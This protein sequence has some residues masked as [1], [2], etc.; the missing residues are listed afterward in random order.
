MS[1]TPD[2]KGNRIGAQTAAY[3]RSTHPINWAESHLGSALPVAGMLAGGGM[4]AA[5][6]PET[7]GAS[8]SGLGASAGTGGAA[9]L[10]GKQAIGKSLGVSDMDTD[11]IKQEGVNDAVMEMAGRGVGQLPLPNAVGGSVEG[12]LGK[13]GDMARTTVTKPLSYLAGLVTGVPRQA[14]EQ[15][16]NDP[17]GVAMANS[18]KTAKV[19]SGELSARNQ[20]LGRIVGQ[21]RE[22]ALKAR[23]DLSFD[24][25]GT[26]NEIGAN[27]DEGVRLGHITPEEGDKL[28]AI[29]DQYLTTPHTK[30]GIPAPATVRAPWQR[31]EL[32]PET[33][34]YRGKHPENGKGDWTLDP[35]E[36]RAH[37]GPEGVVQ[38]SVLGNLG[39]EGDLIGGYAG[40]VQPEGNQLVPGVMKNV[41]RGEAIPASQI[42][43]TREVPNPKKWTVPPKQTQLPAASMDQLVQGVGALSPGS[44]GPSQTAMSKMANDV[45]PQGSDKYMAQLAQMRGALKAVDDE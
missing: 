27:V 38:P 7:L 24:S 3:L 17:L 8:L 26:L 11:A 28:K 30:P 19:A 36:A 35:A 25:S 12:A 21:T 18:L 41:P 22:A 9:G 42:P 39:K 44:S 45:V 5:L 31:G 1:T 37:A 34:V 2:A 33:P 40:A 13:L 43:V 16:M 6:A 20:L 29:A 32:G 4:A 23:G 10:A 15:L 14:A